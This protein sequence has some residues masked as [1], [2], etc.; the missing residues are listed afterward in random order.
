MHLVNQAQ[1]IALAKA[2]AADPRDDG[3]ERRVAERTPEQKA[4]VAAIYERFCREH[5]AVKG[6]QVERPQARARGAI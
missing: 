4:R 5:A 6:E 1:W 3:F 2:R